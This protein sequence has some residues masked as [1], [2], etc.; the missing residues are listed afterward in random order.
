MTVKII[1]RLLLLLTVAALIIFFIIPS[2]PLGVG[3]AAMALMYIVVEKEF[4]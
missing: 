3:V 1:H 2:L 4:E